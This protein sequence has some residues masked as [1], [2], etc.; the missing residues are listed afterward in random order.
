MSVTCGL[1]LFTLG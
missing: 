1:I